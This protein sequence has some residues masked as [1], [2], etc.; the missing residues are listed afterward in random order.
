MPFVCIRDTPMH[1]HRWHWS[2][3]GRRKQL[4]YRIVVICIESNSK[5][6]IVT[7]SIIRRSSLAIILVIG[8]CHPERNQKFVNAIAVKRNS[9]LIE[10]SRLSCC[11]DIEQITFIYIARICMVVNVIKILPLIATIP[12]YSIITI[13]I[14]T[15]SQS[16]ILKNIITLAF[17]QT[18][19]SIDS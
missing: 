15:L 7:I 12:S 11:I 2:R 9:I 3:S 14:I 18:G 6:R 17:R 10:N 1:S 5:V 4:P 13:I 16:I 8:I 19:S